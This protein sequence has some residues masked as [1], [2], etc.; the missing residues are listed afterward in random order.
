MLGALAG[1]DILPFKPD[2]L[3]GVILESVPKE[4]IGINKKAFELGIK[5]IKK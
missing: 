5:S 3:L 4:Y 1:A 2:F